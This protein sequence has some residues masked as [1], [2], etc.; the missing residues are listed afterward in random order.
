MYYFV[1]Q[2]I[3]FYL[4]IFI[5]K[6]PHTYFHNKLR[7]PRPSL[8]IKCLMIIAGVQDSNFFIFGLVILRLFPPNHQATI[9]VPF[10]ILFNS[11][12]YEERKK[13][14]MAF[15]SIFILQKIPSSF[16]HSNFSSAHFSP[17]SLSL[18]SS[19]DA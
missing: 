6:Y 19:N 14:I 9:A 5:G 2:D 1:Y 11:F 15:T 8:N 10:K 4:Q 16:P 3:A 13:N 12:Y 7:K 18:V 17:V